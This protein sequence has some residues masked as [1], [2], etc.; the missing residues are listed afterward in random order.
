MEWDE[1]RDLIQSAGYRY[2]VPALFADADAFAAFCADLLEPYD[3]GEVDQVAGIDA[4][5]F[6]PGAVLAWEL[7]A[8]FVSVRKGGKL[9]IEKGHRISDSLVDYTGEEKTLE[10]DTRMVDDGA[11]TLL[12]D[13]WMETAS[14]M[15]TAL[16]LLERAGA[17]VMGIAVLG[18]RGS[19]AP[20]GQPEA[21][22]SGDAEENEVPLELDE[23]YGVHTIRPWHE[24]GT[25]EREQ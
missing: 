23:A 1:Y 4:I 2:N 20:A 16:D 5:G 22:A 19:A 24:L 25:L 9:P 3:A 6:A 8:G 18:V 10:L 13:D 11:R 17:D 12:V 21:S 15:T 14:Q 7:D